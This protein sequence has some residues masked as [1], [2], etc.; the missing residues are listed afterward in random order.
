MRKPKN[1]KEADLQERFIKAHEHTYSGQ[2]YRELR[3]QIKREMRRE[4]RKESK[5][6]EREETKDYLENLD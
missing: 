2:E 4:D 6:I 3:R 1:T 5:R